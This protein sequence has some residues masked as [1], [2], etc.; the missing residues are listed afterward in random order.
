MTSDP[1]YALRIRVSPP[2]GLSTR[3]HADPYTHSGCRR[4]SGRLDD[5]T[6]HQSPRLEPDS[7]HHRT[8]LANSVRPAHSRAAKGCPERSSCA[9]PEILAS[10]QRMSVK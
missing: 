1:A 3:S 5:H 9:G 7:F 10:C 4:W 8:R 2:V 6:T